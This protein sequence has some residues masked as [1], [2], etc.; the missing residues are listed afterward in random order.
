MSDIDLVTQLNA[1]CDSVEQNE[2]TVGDGIV[3]LREIMMDV[4][5]QNTKIADE[6]R[7][8]V[9]MINLVGSRRHIA[10]EY[11]GLCVIDQPNTSEEKSKSPEEASKN[12]STST[13]IL[14]SSENKQNIVKKKP[15]KTWRCPELE[16]IEESS[17]DS[18]NRHQKGRLKYAQ[19]EAA[20]AELNLGLF[21]K[22]KLLANYAR[23]KRKIP[24]ADI[25][26]YFE[27]SND[28]PSGFIYLFSEEDLAK[29]SFSKLKHT[30][31]SIISI[32]KSQG[33]I[34]EKRRPRKKTL[35]CLSNPKVKELPL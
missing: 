5:Q 9:R 33:R 35:Y 14:S 27:E 8:I 7:G 15:G 10:D 11:Q 31:D 29:T 17:F 23:K 18:M 28:I 32:L 13:N 25:D 2:M 22:Y 34:H 16:Q 26:R 24:T 30:K 1:I 19:L 20:V 6:T 12:I 21:L 4:E 3:R